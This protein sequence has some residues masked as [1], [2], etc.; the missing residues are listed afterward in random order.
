MQAKKYSIKQL[1]IDDQPREKLL[2]KSPISL[3]DS[4]LIAILINLGTPEKNA[5]ELARDVLSLGKNDLNIL[6]RLSVKDIMEIRGIGLAKAMN[7]VAALELGRRRQSAYLFSK[8]VVRTSRDVASYLQAMLQDHTHEV[9][10][11]LFLNQGNR[12]NHFSLISQGGITATVADVRI[13][14]KKALQ[15]EAVSIILCHNHPSGSLIPSQADVDL[16]RKI[17]EAAKLFDIKLMDH[18]IVS[19]EGYYS[20]ADGGGL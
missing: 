11:V 3:S 7:I 19:S 1:A 13:I 9:F 17:R 6:G 14:I 4:E 20:M 5:L 18:I 16:T 8:P 10:G 15:E 12:I 2:R